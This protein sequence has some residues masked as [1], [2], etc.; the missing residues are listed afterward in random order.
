MRRASVIRDPVASDGSRCRRLRHL[1][2]KPGAKASFSEGRRRTRCGGKQGK[3]QPGSHLGCNIKGR[4]CKGK[5]DGMASLTR[6]FGK[7]SSGLWA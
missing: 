1:Q 6:R 2:L 5:G 4:L 3:V 7:S